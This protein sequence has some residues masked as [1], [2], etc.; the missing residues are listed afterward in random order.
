MI[1]TIPD[2]NNDCPI[3]PKQL[4]EFEI[5]KS[6]RRGSVIKQVIVSDGD[7]GINAAVRYCLIPRLLFL[8]INLKATNFEL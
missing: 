5:E 1:V 4:Y 3:F 7:T 8:S 2:A 6:M